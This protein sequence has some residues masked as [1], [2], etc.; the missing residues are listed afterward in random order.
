MQRDVFI[1]TC[2][3]NPLFAYSDIPLN[4]NHFYQGKNTCT[5]LFAA[6]NNNSNPGLVF[7]ED[8]V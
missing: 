4:H 3:K 6:V 5:A 2:V 8:L 7:Y 1:S